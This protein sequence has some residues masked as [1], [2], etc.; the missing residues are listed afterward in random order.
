[1]LYKATKDELQTKE[2]MVEKLRDVRKILSFVI[3]IS[4]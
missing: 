1:M 3:P 4:K 2:Q